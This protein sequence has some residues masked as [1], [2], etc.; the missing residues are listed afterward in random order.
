METEKTFTDW[1]N[2]PENPEIA[3]AELE[4]KAKEKAASDAYY[5]EEERKRQEQTMFLILSC[6]STAFL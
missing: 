4:R 6:S 3:K 5:E 1:L 2:N